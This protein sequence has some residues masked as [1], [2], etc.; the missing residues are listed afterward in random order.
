MAVLLASTLATSVH[1]QTRAETRLP[2]AEI[3]MSPAGITRTSTGSYTTTVVGIPGGG[4]AYLPVVYATFFV[5]PELALEPAVMY[6]HES[7]G[8]SSDWFGAMLLRAAAYGPG[9]QANSAYAFLET[10]FIGN[11]ESN[12]GDLG[13]GA[14]YRW[15]VADQHAALRLEGFYRRWTTTPV[16]S[17]LG[18]AVRVGLVIPRSR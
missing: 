15:L 11:G 2:A 10:G 3:G 1:A 12:H 13:A 14:G 9:A 8:N 6:L 5:L 16:Q 17:E 7:T 18:L 4:V